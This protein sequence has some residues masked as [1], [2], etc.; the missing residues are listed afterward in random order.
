MISLGMIVRDAEATLERCLTSVAPFVDEIVIGL[1]GESTDRTEEIARKF[2]DRV[3]QLEWHDDFAEARNSVL[4]KCTGDYFLWL[5]ADDELIGGEHMKELISEHPEV[6]AFYWGYDYA[7]DGDTNTCYLIRERLIKLS[8]GWMWVGPVHEVLAGPA[9]HQQFLSGDLLVK[10]YPQPKSAT[11]NLDI[12]YRQLEESE[13]NPDPRVL[14]YLGTENA[15]RGNLH[16]ALLHLNRYIKISQWTEEKYQ[17][18]HRIADIYR[19]LRDFE[20]SRL[21]DFKAIRIR[22][23]WPDAYLGLAETAYYDGK[24][25]ECIEWT[26]AASTKEAPNTLLIINPRDYDYHPLVFVGLA[27]AQL[28]DIEMARQNL[29]RAFT[30]KPEE[31]IQ[32]Y[33]IAFAAENEARQL[34]SSFTTVWEHL[35]KYDEWLKARTLWESLPQVLEKL[36]ELQSKRAFT[37]QVTAHVEEPELMVNQ[38]ITNPHWKPVND[39]VLKSAD[40]LRHSRLQF[41]LAVA[42]RTESKNVVDLGCSDGFI[43]L[44]LAR[45]LPKVQVTGIDLDPRCIALAQQRATDWVLPHSSFLTE[46]ILKYKPDVDQYYDLALLFEVIEHVV[47]AESVLD[48]LGSVAKHVAITT[49]LLTWEGP[50]QDWLDTDLKQHLRI[51]SFSDLE[52]LLSPRGR[53]HNLYSEQFAP[54]ASTMFADYHPGETT[55]GHI[56]ILAPNTPEAWTPKSFE[57]EG[58]GG[59]ETA[60]IRLSEELA[61]LG[62]SV[63]VYSRMASEGYFNRVRYRDQS[64][65]MSGIHSDVFVAWRAP[66][67]IDDQPNATRAI[68]WMHDTDVGDRLTAIRA[69]KFEGIVVLTEWHKQHMMSLYPFISEE[70]FWVCPNGVDLGRFTTEPVPVRNPHRVVYSSSPDRGLDTILE[71]IWPSVVAKSP[72][73]ELHVYYG[74]NNFDKFIPM[75]P[76][77]AETKSKLLQLIA[78]SKNVTLHGRVSQSELAT[79]MRKS[80]VWLYPTQ[81]TETYCITAVEAQL[82]GLIPV[83]NNLAALAETVKSGYIIPGDVND[84]EVIAEYIR[85]TFQAMGATDGERPSIVNNAPAVSWAEVANRWSNRWLMHSTAKVEKVS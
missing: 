37:Y 53:I 22:P 78:S 29:E 73:A 47:D 69:A 4:E 43:S 39:E 84:P 44:P 80:G 49:P 56:T 31:S 65:Y 24:Y 15:S 35:A 57:R 19:V 55:L 60:V 21:S 74:W 42:R 11:R 36:P 71:H 9:N 67:L 33:L 63:D 26:K 12:L 25:E 41:A 1:G 34:L 14:V 17:A 68:L 77:L 5:D 13:P 10:H 66:E 2:T 85:S 50:R 18:Q 83:T 72:E 20:K 59:S 45:E 7:R 46:D 79:E 62:I 52:R 23:D 54:N 51:F 32:K 16:E 8:S 38:Y 40:W 30:I 81:F 75:F 58:L 70:K 3:H 48:H 28:G 76:Q 82:A 61:G 64:R 27:Y 6:D